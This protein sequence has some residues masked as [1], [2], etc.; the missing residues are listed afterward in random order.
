M[1]E[2]RDF[3]K[4][5]NEAVVSDRDDLEMSFRDIGKKYSI[6]GNRAKQIYDQIYRERTEP[7][8]SPFD[9]SNL[10]D[11]L[12]DDLPLSNRFKNCIYYKGY[13]R[14]ELPINRHFGIGHRQKGFI[15]V[16]DIIH[17]EDHVLLSVDGFG[18][19]TLAE[20]RDFLKEMRDA[21]QL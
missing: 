8:K 17:F 12:I 2:I 11:K 13:E 7:T 16:S 20:W 10:L 5:R 1:K 19:G 4:A 3:Y 15:K 6:S 18:R 9:P 21:G 14:Y